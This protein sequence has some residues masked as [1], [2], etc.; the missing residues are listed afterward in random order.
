MQHP[1]WLARTHTP[2]PPSTTPFL[3]PRPTLLPCPQPPEPTSGLD[4]CSALAVVE[5]LRDRARDSGLT[6]VCSIH[7]PRAAVWACFDACAVLA[8]GM[9]LYQGPCGALVGW[10]QGSLGYGPWDS[11]V[12][13][14]ASDWVMDLV[15]VGFT[16]PEVRGAGEQYFCMQLA[17]RAAGV[18]PL[19]LCF[20]EEASA[21]GCCRWRSRR[22]LG[23]SVD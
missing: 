18:T 14:T 9:G 23:S 21:R 22:C 12:H 10:F 17:D 2:E 20:W 5:H 16:K 19:W 15:N 7:Q 8:G 1:L 13:G 3:L 6:V 4:S 11:A